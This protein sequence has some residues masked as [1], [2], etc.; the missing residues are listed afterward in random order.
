LAE[1]NCLNLANNYA[2]WPH[3]RS[4]E[5]RRIEE[6]VQNHGQPVLAISERSGVVIEQDEMRIVGFEPSYRFDHQ[7][8]F[9]I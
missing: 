9:E 2:V 3:Y 7:A 8:K 5:D 4:G 6:F 1:V